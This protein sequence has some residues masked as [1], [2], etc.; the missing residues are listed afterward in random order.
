MSVGAVERVR[1]WLSYQRYALL[2]G[3]VPPVVVAAVVYAGPHRWW[4]WAPLGLVAL[5]LMAF[6]VGI[7]GRLPRKFRA[8]LLA[9]RRI[10]AG[11]FRPESVARYSGDPCFRVVAYEILRRA[12]MPR[13]ERRDLVGRLAE[14]QAARDQTMVLVNREDGVL[15]HIDGSTVTRHALGGTDGG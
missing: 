14:E 15:F 1:L 5:K 2:L 6:A 3:V 12:G 13:A 7:H 4:L 11:R 8:T 10:A 9:D